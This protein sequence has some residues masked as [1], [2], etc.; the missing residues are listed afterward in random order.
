MKA[1]RRHPYL[2]GGFE[3]WKVRRAEDRTRVGKAPDI[4]RMR[5]DLLKYSDV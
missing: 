4:D 3:N 1:G 2:Q 5:A